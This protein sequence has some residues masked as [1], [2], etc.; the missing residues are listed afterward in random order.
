MRRG[1]GLI[2]ALALAAA[3]TAACG[4]SKSK[5]NTT[6]TVRSTS[7]TVAALSVTVTPSSGGVGSVFTFKVQ[8]FESGE[9]LHFE[10]VFPNNSHTFVGQSHP[11]NADGTYAAPYNSTK[12]NPTGTYTVKAIGDQGSTAEGTFELTSGAPSSGGGGTTESTS[13]TVASSDQTLPGD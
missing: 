10:V 3:V 5:S 6:T 11:V 4:N 1:W 8:G 2:A 9:H 7:T 13:T 12:G